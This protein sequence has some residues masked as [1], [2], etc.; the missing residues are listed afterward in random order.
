MT[1][2]SS[3][4][5]C[6]DGSPVGE[7]TGVVGNYGR[8]VA[9]RQPWQRDAVRALYF[10]FPLGAGG[11]ALYLLIRDRGGLLEDLTLKEN[12]V[13]VAVILGLWLVAW[14]YLTMARR[15]FEREEAMDPGP[16]ELPPRDI[17]DM[18]GQELA[19]WARDDPEKLHRLIRRLK[20]R[21]YS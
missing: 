14:L 13:V 5:L 15:R 6:W 3:W 8:A 1:V 7:Q 17:K 21:R 11:S 18:T 19:E 12:V 4:D 20:R 9:G 10:A 16:I 2:V